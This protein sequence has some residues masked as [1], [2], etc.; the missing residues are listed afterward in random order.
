MKGCPC[1]DKLSRGMTRRTETAC[2]SF[3]IRIVSFPAHAHAHGYKHVM[4]VPNYQ[5]VTSST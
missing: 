5:H 4:S 1:S 2:L 3:R